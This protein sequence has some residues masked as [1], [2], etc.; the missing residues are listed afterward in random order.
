MRT[1]K[2]TLSRLVQV[3]APLNV[4]PTKQASTKKPLT[5]AQRNARIKQL[6]KELAESKALLQT[7]ELERS[8]TKQKADLNEALPKGAIIY[9]HTGTTLLKIDE[10]QAYSLHNQLYNMFHPEVFDF[11]GET[12]VIFE[13][14]QSSVENA[15]DKDWAGEYVRVCKEWL[16]TLQ[17]LYT[18]HK[19]TQLANS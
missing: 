8:E 11:K 6:E 9:S 15:E 18:I 7:Q 4:P 16:S 12:K 3:T 5:V 14:L 2:K 13:M 19:D 10:V 1:T 17:I